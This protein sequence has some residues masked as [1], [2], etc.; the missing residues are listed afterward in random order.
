MR[1]LAKAYDL[2]L[3]GMA[4]A[5][6]LLMVAIMAFI[7]TDVALRNLGTQSSAHLFTFNEYALLL[8]PLLGSPW[9]VREKGHIYIE[10]V[11]SQMPAAVQRMQIRLIT[12]ACIVVCLVLAWYGAEVTVKD[13]VQNEKD[14]RS[15]DM[16]RWM[17]M[18]FMPLCFG[19]MA[20]EFGR[21]LARGE[22]IYGA[23]AGQ[24]SAPPRD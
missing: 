4:V 15:L 1:A 16:P 5:A 6:G 7:V 9:L 13:W 8:V 10:L 12:I 2:L 24:R 22:S 11:L 17:L 23:I 21:F 19:M 14:V 3:L 20:V 18:A